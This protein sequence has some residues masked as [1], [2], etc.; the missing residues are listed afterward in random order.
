RGQGE[1]AVAVPGEYV[2]RADGIGALL[3]HRQVAELVDHVQLTRL[4][5]KTRAVRGIGTAAAQKPLQ[6]PGVHE[7]LAG[8]GAARE[9]TDRDIGEIRRCGAELVDAREDV[10]EP[11]AA[12]KSVE[13]DRGE[14][15]RER[16]PRG[17]QRLKYEPDRA[18][19][20]ARGLQV[21]IVAVLTVKGQTRVVGAAEHARNHGLT[22]L[23]R[24]DGA[25]FGVQARG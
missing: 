18:R 17:E 5:G 23:P 10:V 7:R 1:R 22:H 19:H 14:V 6:I 4:A 13:I 9:I 8:V 11:E 25:V 2:A 24:V 3:Q 15:D 21:R 12:G 20:R 16:Q